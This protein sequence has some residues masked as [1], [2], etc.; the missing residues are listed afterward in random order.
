[1]SIK[2]LFKNKNFLMFFGFSSL[3]L[4][5]FA[6]NNIE[7]II[8]YKQEIT[9]RAR[10]Y[11]QEVAENRRKQKELEEKIERTK[12]F[13][14]AKWQMIKSRRDTFVNKDGDLIAN[15]D[16]KIEFSEIK[17]EWGNS[18]DVGIKEFNVKL[19]SSGPDGIR[20]NEDDIVY[21]QKLPN[22][23]LYNTFGIE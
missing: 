14:A 8:R 12:S 3:L 6:K 7:S 18:I 1:M 15:E 4:V 5:A 22:G 17:D 11:Q 20:L 9:E 13:L 2:K 19:G 21:E 16:N 10:K 23:F